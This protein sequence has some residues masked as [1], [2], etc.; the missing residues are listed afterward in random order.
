[1]YCFCAII[2][3]FHYSPGSLWKPLNN[4]D[5]D[6]SMLSH[7]LLKVM[8]WSDS[9]LFKCK[10]EVISLCASLPWAYL[11]AVVAK[12]FGLSHWD[13][14]WNKFVFV[15]GLAHSPTNHK[16]PMK[17]V[18]CTMI[19]YPFHNLE[20]IAFN[21]SNTYKLPKPERKWLH[22]STMQSSTIAQ[23]ALN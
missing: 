20:Y 16:I 7:H 22:L 2:L 1:M 3:T 11:H 18:K 19:W 23:C 17:Q 5:F 4:V 21:I 9:L 6:K 10:H 8:L 12:I 15:E 13:I 14:L